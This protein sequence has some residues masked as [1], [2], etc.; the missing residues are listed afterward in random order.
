MD[1][2]PVLDG[3]GVVLEPTN[4]LYCLIGVAVG[5]L[6]GALPVLGPMA[7]I[8]ISLPITIGIES[9][10]AIIVL[11]GILYGAHYGATNT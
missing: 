10:T 5:I 11:A 6:V 9:L 2:A 1:L 8:A 4:L 7:T 3:F